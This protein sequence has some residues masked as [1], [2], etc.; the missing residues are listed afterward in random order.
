MNGC[1]FLN[2]VILNIG[3]WA[4]VRKRDGYSIVLWVLWR[5]LTAEYDLVL[6]KL[7]TPWNVLKNIKDVFTFRIISWIFVHR[8]KPNTQWSSPIYHVPYTDNAIPA[9]A[10][11]GARALAG[12][13]LAPATLGARASAGIVLAP[14]AGIFRFQHQKVNTVH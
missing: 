3:N 14:K 5:N 1:V 7:L 10:T 2:M 12:M 8:R 6:F 9:D 4:C 11:L 13:V